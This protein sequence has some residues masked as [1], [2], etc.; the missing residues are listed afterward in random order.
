V[1][2]PA[3]TSVSDQH[4]FRRHIGKAQRLRHRLMRHLAQPYVQAGFQVRVVADGLR[5]VDASG[6][7]KHHL[8]QHPGPDC[9]AGLEGI[10]F[11]LGGSVEGKANCEL[12]TETERSLQARM[13]AGGGKQARAWQSLSLGG[14]K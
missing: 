12:R 9:D 7:S 4:P 3:G 1:S 8:G 6:V 14:W 13:W 11:D 5:V 10:G 2:C